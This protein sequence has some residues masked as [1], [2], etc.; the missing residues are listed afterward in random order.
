MTACGSNS[1]K[2]RKRNRNYKSARTTYN[3]EHKRTVNPG[4][5]AVLSKNFRRKDTECER[6]KNCNA[7]SENANDWSVVFCKTGNKFFAFC[8]CFGSFF[9]QFQNSCDCAFAISFCNANSYNA[10]A[11]YKSSQN[12]T[13]LINF[14]RNA[15]SCQRARVHK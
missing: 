12:C 7:K 13:S 10:L 4:V 15:F 9:R 2:K 3:Q 5:P 6:R 1:A 8:L 11:V 14:S